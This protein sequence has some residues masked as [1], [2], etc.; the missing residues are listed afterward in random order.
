MTN[1]KMIIPEI[2]SH[3]KKDT[4]CYVQMFEYSTITQWRDAYMTQKEKIK[5]EILKA[6]YP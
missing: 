1:I 6:F 4:G 5:K 3:C 2:T